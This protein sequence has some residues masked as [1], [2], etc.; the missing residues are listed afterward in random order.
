MATITAASKNGAIPAMIGQCR[1]GY[2]ENTIDFAVTPCGTTTDTV[3]V[4]DLPV[5]NIVRQAGYEIMHAGTATATFG[6]GFAG[7][8]ELIAQGCA[9]D[10]AAGSEAVSALTQETAPLSSAAARKLTLIMAVAVAIHG[11]VRVWA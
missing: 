6:M 7:G 11:K 2:I 8:Q 1:T 9:L 3:N 4:F 10:A 5:H